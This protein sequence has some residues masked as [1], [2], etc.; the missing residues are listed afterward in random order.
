MDF[1]R[2]AV[3]GARICRIAHHERCNGCDG[4]IHRTQRHAHIHH[5]NKPAEQLC[6]QCID[7]T[8]T[9][10]QIILS[11]LQD[12]GLQQIRAADLIG[13][14]RD[15]RIGILLQASIEFPPTSEN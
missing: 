14:A 12:A 3:G 8:V 9:A 10:A 15:G 1:N 11:A 6:K 7:L 13:L 2:A 4:I 5:G